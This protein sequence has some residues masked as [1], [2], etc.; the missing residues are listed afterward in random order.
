MDPL[1]AWR[2]AKVLPLVRGRLLDLACGYSNL[3]RSYGTGVGVDVYPWEGIDVLIEDAAQLPFRA[4]V[5]QTVSVVAALNHIPNRSHA[6]LEIRR[7]LEPGGLLLTTMIGPLTGRVAHLL[8]HHDE[9]E[10]GGMR[11]GEVHGLPP[12]EM[13][14]LLREAGFTVER[15][16]P[17]Q[18]RL[19]R[20]YV[21]RRE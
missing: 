9:H 8:F 5:F 14:L 12:S 10:R 18:L 3:V 4:G 15:E 21:A 1:E 20:L 2:L 13:R 19:N 16:I 11:P 17:F 6:L 7:V